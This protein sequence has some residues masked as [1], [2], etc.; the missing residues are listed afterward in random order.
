MNKQITLSA[1][2][3][4]LK[5][6]STRKKEFVEQMNGLIPWGKWISFVQPCYYKGERGNKPYEL[7]FMLRINLL[8]HLDNLADEAVASEVMD[9][10]AFSEFCG[11]DSSNQ[12]PDGDTT[13]RFRSLLI[14]NNLDQKLFEQAAALL[15]ARGLL[16]KKGTI[17]DST[18]IAAPSSAKDKDRKRDPD[19]HQV[20]KGNER[21]FGYKAHIGTDQDSGLVHHAEATAANVSDVSVTPKLLSGK[22]E[23]VYGDSGCLGAQKRD[24]AVIRN[25]LGKKLRYRINRKPSQIRKLS[26]RGQDHAR[27]VERAKSSVRSKA[28]PVS[29][30][31]KRLFGFRKTR[32]RGLRKQEAELNMLFAVKRIDGLAYAFCLGFAYATLQ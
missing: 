9:S 7:E 20:K 1:I 15:E 3:D 8:R 13:G 10:R 2:S 21:H 26:Q 18:L 6:A 12:V 16:L 11:V 30:V 4:E 23:N 24:D 28:E 29:A 27:R 31:V 22:E 17:V 5:Q 32:Y 19:A 14:K 25:K